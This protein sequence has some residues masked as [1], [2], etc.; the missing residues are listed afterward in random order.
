MTQNNYF[1]I[2]ISYFARSQSESDTATQWARSRFFV[3]KPHISVNFTE[4]DKT[5]VGLSIYVHSSPLYPRNSYF[6]Q[7]RPKNSKRVQETQLFLD[8][9]IVNLS[10]S[11]LKIPSFLNAQ[12][13]CEAPS[14]FR[15][16]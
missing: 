9:S 7:K 12:G 11:V 13:Y 8:I 16:L 2:C 4:C 14:D 5:L 10:K 15:W 1:G 6:T 3:H